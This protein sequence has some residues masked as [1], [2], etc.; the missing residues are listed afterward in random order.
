[1]ITSAAVIGIY[2]QINIALQLNEIDQ[3]AVFT[4]GVITNDFE[5]GKR[6]DP[7]KDYTFNCNN[8]TYSGQFSDPFLRL[9]VGDSIRIK[10]ASKHPQFNLA[11][12]DSI[13]K[14]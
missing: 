6:H 3:Y 8:K 1:M 10:Y 7:Y 5:R 2:I 12:V 14:K 13:Y 4:S 11:L 9:K